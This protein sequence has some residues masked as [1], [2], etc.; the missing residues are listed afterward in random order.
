MKRITSN[1]RIEKTDK[2]KKNWKDNWKMVSWGPC[3]GDNKDVKTKVV[4][5]VMDKIEPG[6]EI[7]KAKELLKDRK[8]LKEFVKIGVFR[9][10]FRVSDFNGRNV[11]IKDGNKLVS[12]DEG[13]IGKRVDILGGNGKHKWLIKAL[14]RDK[15]IIKEIL[16]E[17]ISVELPLVKSMPIIVEKMEKYKFGDELIREVC[18][19]FRNL[20]AD[21]KNEGVEF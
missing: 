17:L 18:K 15:S 10:I 4:Y 1:F 11:L 8:I 7:G 16:S 6:I 2:S 5:C 20:L 14:N 19:N 13:D 12:I 9:G 21:L 3:V